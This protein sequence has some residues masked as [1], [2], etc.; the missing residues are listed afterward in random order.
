MNNID[1]KNTISSTAASFLQT[2]VHMNEVPGNEVL[3]PTPL[4]AQQKGLLTVLKKKGL[5]ETHNTVDEDGNS[6]LAATLSNAALQFVMDTA[7]W[8]NQTEQQ[9]GVEVA[10]APDGA[11]QQGPAKQRKSCAPKSLTGIF[12]MFTPLPEG[13]TKLQK[14]YKG[15]LYTAIVNEDGSVSMDIDM[16]ELGTEFRSLTHAAR[17]ITGYKNISGRKFFGVAGK[18]IPAQEV[19]PDAKIVADAGE[20][21]EMDA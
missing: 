1:I 9:P 17:A 19:M 16:G 10:E 8:E 2:I 7:P 6:H 3:L 15:Q 5:V 11:E 14:I 18:R 20:A 13:G 4:T 12:G 21:A